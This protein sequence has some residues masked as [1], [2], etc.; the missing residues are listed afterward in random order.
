[1]VDNILIIT[2]F[3][4]LKNLGYIDPGAL[5]GFMAIVIGGIVG[6]GMTLKLYWYK[7]KQKISRNKID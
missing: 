1:L 5:T 7:I 6:V 4:L 3:S 2:G